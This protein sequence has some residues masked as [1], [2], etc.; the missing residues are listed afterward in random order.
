MSVDIRKIKK[1]E[2]KKERVITLPKEKK[3]KTKV[4][5]INQG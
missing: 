5:R 3:G 2:R 4:R 1:K